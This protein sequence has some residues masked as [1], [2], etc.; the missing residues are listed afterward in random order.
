MR[1]LTGLQ[2]AIDTLV[3]VHPWFNPVASDSTLEFIESVFGPGISPKQA[4]NMII[5]RV[6]SDGDDGVKSL[7]ALMDGVDIDL[8]LIHI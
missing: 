4:I 8:S 2:N 7:T 6:V 1:I 3:P 5:E